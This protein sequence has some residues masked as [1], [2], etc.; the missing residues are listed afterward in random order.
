MRRAAGGKEAERKAGRSAYVGDESK[1]H[2]LQAERD[3]IGRESLN[4]DPHERVLFDNDGGFVTVTAGIDHKE[5]EQRD[6]DEDVRRHFES[7][8]SPSP[9]LLKE[10]NQVDPRG[11]KEEDAPLC[12]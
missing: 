1:R 10:V 3:K 7:Q 2:A 8:P 12:S 6:G 11:R 5:V 9:R 4:N